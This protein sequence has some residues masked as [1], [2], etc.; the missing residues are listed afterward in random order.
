MTPQEVKETDKDEEQE[1]EKEEQEVGEEEV[2]EWLGGWCRGVLLLT[3][4]RG[5]DGLDDL[6]DDPEANIEEVLLQAEAAEQQL[7][8]S[9]ESGWQP[10]QARQAAANAWVKCQLLDE[11]DALAGRI[12]SVLAAQGFRLTHE[13][14]KT[15]S[16]GQFRDWLLDRTMI[17]EAGGPAAQE[18]TA[19]PWPVGRQSAPTCAETTV[20]RFVVSQLVPCA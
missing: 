12:E 19:A 11:S 17:D 14:K 6:D 8:Q 1:E 3:V 5:H 4:S 15:V 7:D 2:H 13:V 20:P 9:N 10:L 18:V 16:Y